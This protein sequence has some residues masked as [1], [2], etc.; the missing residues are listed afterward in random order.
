MKVIN[1]N[2]IN[3]KE[4]TSFQRQINREEEITRLCKSEYTVNLY[5]KLETK[6]Y[7]IFELEYFDS[8]IYKYIQNNGPLFG[9]LNFFKYIVHQLANALKILHQ[10]GIMHRDIKPQNIFLKAINGQNK[11]KLGNFSRSIFIKDNTSEPI[12]T[13]IYSS[14]E[15]ISETEYN[16][17]SDLWSLGITLF[18]IFF[19]YPP[20]GPEPTPDIINNIVL[21][22]KNNFIIKKTNIPTLDILFKRLLVINPDIRM[23][24]NEFVNYVFSQDFMKKDVIY[25]NNTKIYKKLYMNILKEPEVK[26]KLEK[27]EKTDEEIIHKE[28]VKKLNSISQGENFPDTMNFQNEIKEKYNNIIFYDERIEYIHSINKDSDYFEKHTPGAFILCTDLESLR[29]VRAEILNEIQKNSRITFNLI[30][31]GSSFTKIIKFLKEDKR[32]ESCINKVCI[33]CSNL[34]KYISLKSIYNKIHDDMYTRKHQVVDFI[35]KFSSKEIKPFPLIKLKT[36]EDYIK[37][38]K[39]RHFKVSSF[40]GDLTLESYQKYIKEM[41]DLIEK[42]SKSHE[43]IKDENKVFNGFL[44]FDLEKGKDIKEIDVLII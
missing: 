31:T 39:N 4:H 35:K 22:D 44:T 34:E 17:K 16:E 7:I 6:E 25:V 20:Y 9:D 23:S 40:Y 43:L 14:P 26:F 38:F 11:I 29:L 13:F 18:E 42:K 33:Y 32:F 8:T 3:Y 36:Y 5:R 41:R 12:G 27:P 15:I 1:K 2:D 30:I 21:D 28:C 24:Y 10:K 37:K 19:G